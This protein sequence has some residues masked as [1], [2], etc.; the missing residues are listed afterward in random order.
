MGK[1]WIKS[2]FTFIVVIGERCE[3][4]KRACKLYLVG[5]KKIM[6]IK[7]KISTL[8]HFSLQLSAIVEQ[9]SS[10]CVLESD[11]GFAVNCNF[12]KSGLFRIRNLG[13]AKLN[14]GLGRLTFPDTK[15]LEF[16]FYSIN[17][18]VLFAGFS[19]GDELGF[20]E[21]LGNVEAVKKRSLD[22][23][24][25]EIQESKVRDL[26]RCSHDK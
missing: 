24:S 2:C 5:L 17:H 7:K 3:T 15:F 14:F 19:L 13:G 20:P 4:C 18:L 1:L 10:V 9:T 6:M 12:K 25:G 11:F 21:S 26:R 8:P 22:V 23:R 16:S